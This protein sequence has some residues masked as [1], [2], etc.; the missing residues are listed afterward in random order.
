MAD[1]L[2]FQPFELRGLEIRNRLWVAP[3]C[4][5]SAESDGE[6]AGAPNDWHLQHLGALGRGGAGLVMVE[7][8]AVSPEGRISPNDLGLWNDE[9]RRAFARIVPVVQAHGARIGIQIA[10][11]GR[12][13]STYNPWT[14]DQPEGAVPIGE[15]GWQPV[16]PSATAFPGLTSPRALTADEVHETIAAFIA[17]ADRAVQAGFDV[18]E[19]HAAHGY[20]LHEFLSPLSNLRDDDYGGS[21][22]SRARPLREIVRGIRAAHPELPIVV[23]V[24]GDE[25]TPGGFDVEAA[26]QLAGWL[27][28]DGADMVDASS[29]GNTANA[30]ITTGPSYQVW[31]AERLRREGLPVSAVG[32]ITSAAQAESIL[33]TGQADIVSLGRPLLANPH[34]PVTW[35]HELR[36]PSSA[37]LIPPQYRRARF[38]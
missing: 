29:A 36:A 33:A 4:Q 5:Y 18:V 35:A 37:A 34:L 22:E 23:R 7:A 20:L 24:S 38:A 3:M 6:L 19:V 9:Q 31:I 2:L 30:K 10:H 32:M 13:A 12:K 17:S 21:P 16:A 14:S 1:P 11:A 8:T 15:G 25:W 28:E 27:G 26:A